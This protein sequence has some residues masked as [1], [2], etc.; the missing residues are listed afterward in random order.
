MEGEQ[1]DEDHLAQIRDSWLG[2]TIENIEPLLAST[3]EHLEFEPDNRDKH[4]LEGLDTIQL[5]VEHGMDKN[6]KVIITAAAAA[7]LA[8]LG[9]AVLMRGRFSPKARGKG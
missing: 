9:I 2:N 3:T 7:S 6:T 5:P 1:I 4:H 8:G